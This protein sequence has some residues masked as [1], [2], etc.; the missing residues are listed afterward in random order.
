MLCLEAA[1]LT[2]GP[3]IIKQPSF[4]SSRFGVKQLSLFPGAGCSELFRDSR[5]KDTGTGLTEPNGVVSRKQSKSCPSR[6][7]GIGAPTC[8]RHGPAVVP[9]WPGQPK[10]PGGSARF[11]TPAL[12]WDGLFVSFSGNSA[13]KLDFQ[14]SDPT[15]PSERAKE[16][17]RERRPEHEL[18]PGAPPPAAAHSP[19]FR[20][21]RV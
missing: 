12:T 10:L 11:T 8:A 4:L 15:T 16:P 13:P 14:P 2:P 6:R 21:K 9:A 3:T 7:L 20:R 18:Q 17:S 5:S 1:L 19:H